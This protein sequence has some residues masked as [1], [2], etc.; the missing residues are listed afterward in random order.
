MLHAGCKGPAELQPPAL[1]HSALLLPCC[2]GLRAAHPAVSAAGCPPFVAWEGCREH[3]GVHYCDRR[4][5]ISELAPRFP[6]VDFSLVGPQPEG[7]TAILHGPW[8]NAG[9][10]VHAAA[11]QGQ[12]GARNLG[13]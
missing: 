1:P 12:E 8:A 13:A 2:Q 9:L 5:S 6:A 3:Y 4:R 7:C 10:L 11:W